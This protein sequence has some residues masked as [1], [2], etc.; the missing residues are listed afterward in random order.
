MHLTETTLI[1]MTN[2]VINM[3]NGNRIKVDYKHMIDVA[4]SRQHYIMYFVTQ[5]H[6]IQKRR[7][8]KG[9]VG[10]VPPVYRI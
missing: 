10:K 1:F 6:G 7:H 9:N 2:S 8:G 5:I 4:R 3:K